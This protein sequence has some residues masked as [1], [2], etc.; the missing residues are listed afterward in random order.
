[1]NQLAI[2]SLMVLAVCPRA[3][4]QPVSPRIGPFVIDLRGTFPN[5]PTTAALA[6]SRGIGATDLP[7]LGLGVNVGAHV[8]LLKW[9]AMT[10][11]LG[12][13]L[14]TA[15]AHSTPAI[16]GFAPVTERFTSVAPQLS[17]NFGSSKG[18]SYLSGGIG[19][20][21]WSIVPE[22][23]QPLPIDQERLKTINYG[24]GARWFAK[25]HLAFTFDVRFYAVNP[26]RPSFGFPG[27]PR[28]RLL[29]IGAGMSVR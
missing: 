10:F 25:R 26:G 6:E 20:S 22:G 5:F 23:S 3:S 12:G 15:R 24:G 14:M 4:A 28:T 2:V 19:P 21:T 9:R 18:W 1:M 16:A 27:S 17:F 11:G 8:Y 29:V 13:E 7:G